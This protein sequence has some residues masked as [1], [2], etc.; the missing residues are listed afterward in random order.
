MNLKARLYS[1]AVATLALVTSL[2]GCSDPTATE[3]LPVGLPHF[4]IQKLPKKAVG[5]KHA[6]PLS[7][8]ISV[9]AVIGEKGG[10]I[11]IKETGF[12]IHFPKKAVDKEITVT[13]TAK[14][15]NVLAYEFQ[16]HGI[17]FNQPVKIIQRLSGVHDS[18]PLGAIFLGYYP[19]PGTLDN[20]LGTALITEAIP[21]E[22]SADDGLIR[23]T[24]SHFSGYLVATGCQEF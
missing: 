13:V 21:A 20:V 22:V 24:I 2:V 11:R 18:S 7:S 14:A 19:D 23:T 10:T 16:P 5:A 3:P 8:D 15:G 9:T 12:S 1:V 6:N 4:G 17:E